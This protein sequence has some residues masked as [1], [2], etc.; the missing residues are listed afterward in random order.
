MNEF[1]RAKAKR[2]KNLERMQRSQQKAVEPVAP[3]IIQVETPAVPKEKRQSIDALIT[4]TVE[5]PT[6]TMEF[7]FCKANVL[8]NVPLN[9]LRRN[10]IMNALIK[11]LEP[12]FG[13]VK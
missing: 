8:Q 9:K 2:L 6:E 7:R 5:L 11:G 13:A 4:V 12:V 1:E 3:P 10:E